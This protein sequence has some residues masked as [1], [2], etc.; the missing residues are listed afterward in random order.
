MKGCVEG[1]LDPG[2]TRSAGQQAISLISMSDAQLMECRLFCPLHSIPF[3]G[4]SM[5]VLPNVCQTMP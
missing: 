5:S 1:G 4:L 2:T 3:Q